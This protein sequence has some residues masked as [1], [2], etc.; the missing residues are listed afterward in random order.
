VSRGIWGYI[1]PEILKNQVVEV[2]FFLH[3]EIHFN[4]PSQVK[5]TFV[6]RE[7]AD[8]PIAAPCLRPCLLSF[9]PKVLNRTIGNSAT[10]IH[11]CRV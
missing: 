3:C 5:W 8:T 9:W 1:F 6:A 7:G 10:C 11:V 4:P 2:R